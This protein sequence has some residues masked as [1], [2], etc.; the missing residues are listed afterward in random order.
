MLLVS[1]DIRNNKLRTRFSKYLSKF[2]GRMQYSVF[3]IRN[4][5]RLLEIIQLGI[6]NDFE[7]HFDQGDSILIFQMSKNCKITRY[8]YAKNEEEDLLII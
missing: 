8:G 7:K 1:Y 2:G 6:R 5:E 3:E 4:S